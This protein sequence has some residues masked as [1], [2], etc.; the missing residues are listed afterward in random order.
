ML[1]TE[2]YND[3]L[4]RIERS[5]S[6]M[7][8]R[9]GKNNRYLLLWLLS[10]GKIQESEWSTLMVR[11]L[12]VEDCQKFLRNFMYCNS[13]RNRNRSLRRKQTKN[14]SFNRLNVGAISNSEQQG[15]G[16]SASVQCSCIFRVSV[17]Y[18][19]QSPF[20]IFKVEENWGEYKMSKW[21]SRRGRLFPSALARP[22][23]EGTRDK[24]LRTPACTTSWVT[25][26]TCVLSSFQLKACTSG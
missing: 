8:M 24:G 11:E 13:S 2:K 16:A 14:G 9:Y 3:N 18:S 19:L 23:G 15:E 25:S 10:H 4:N 12:A 17:Q 6:G 1:Y 26:F 7:R 20:F 5:N 21:G 22:C